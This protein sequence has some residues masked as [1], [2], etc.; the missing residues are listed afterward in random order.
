MKRHSLSKKNTKQQQ[1]K[2]GY[3]PARKYSAGASVRGSLHRDEVHEHLIIDVAGKTWAWP[4][5]PL[6]SSQVFWFIPVRD[7]YQHTNSKPC[8]PFR[9]KKK[10]IDFPSGKYTSHE[11]NPSP[12]NGTMTS[13]FPESTSDSSLRG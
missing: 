1:Q 12:P 4:S 13:P 9:S 8:F 5:R 10:N 3:P 6:W 7:A 11:V 2:T